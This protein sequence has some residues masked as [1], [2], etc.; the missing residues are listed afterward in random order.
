MTAV[1]SGEKRERDV[2]RSRDKER[3]SDVKQCISRT[4]E[5]TEKKSA[6]HRFWSF[7]E[8]LNG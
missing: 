4:M 3:E 8:V 7:K 2:N 6:S 1:K 5:I